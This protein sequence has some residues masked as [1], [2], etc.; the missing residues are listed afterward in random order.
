MP[1]GVDNGSR[2]S[3]RRS[4]WVFNPIDQP[5]GTVQNRGV[6]ETVD[7]MSDSSF[8]ASDPPQA[9]TWETDRRV[10]EKRAGRR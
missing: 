10:D 8:P 3:G 5:Q 1:P 7:E 2:N 6:I 4:E 9:W